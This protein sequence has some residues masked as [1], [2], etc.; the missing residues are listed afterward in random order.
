MLKSAR[1]LTSEEAMHLLSAVRLG[2]GLA[3]LPPVPQRELNEMFLLTQPAHLQKMVARE[4]SPAERDVER[5]AFMRA[6]LS[7]Y[8]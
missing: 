8:Q 6:R 4:L 7:R 1:L 3:V 2:V 5:A